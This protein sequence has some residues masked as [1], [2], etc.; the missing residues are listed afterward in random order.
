ME[1][2]RAHITVE[3]LVQGVCFRVSTVEEA[4][5][6]G[7]TGWVRNNPDGTVEA[8]IEGDKGA[9]KRLLKWCHRGPPDAR[10]TRVNLRWDEYRDE[11]GD[12]RYLTGRDRY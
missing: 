8:V 1:S 2:A 5:R 7:V 3:G 11:F 9:V 4:R 10:V 6:H 12:F